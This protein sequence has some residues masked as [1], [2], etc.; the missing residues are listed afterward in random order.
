MDPSEFTNKV[1][2]LRQVSPCRTTV[3]YR[4]RNA[5]RLPGS[6]SR[7]ID[8]ANR[9]SSGSPAVAHCAEVETQQQQQSRLP[10][11]LSP[12]P[13]VERRRRKLYRTTATTPT[14]QNW[15]QPAAKKNARHHHRN[16]QHTKKMPRLQN[17]NRNFHPV[18]LRMRIHTPGWRRRWTQN[19][20]LCP[21]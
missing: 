20:P 14:S 7:A 13:M 9:C 8:P 6:R 11:D 5:V 18:A 17:S 4:S 1:Q 19:I 12:R 15:P 10:A 2:H 3:I 16:I 21:T